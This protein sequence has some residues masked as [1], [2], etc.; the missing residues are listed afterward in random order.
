MKTEVYNEIMKVIH[1][2]T[3]S[4]VDPRRNCTTLL[5]ERFPDIP[6]YTL[7]SI[8]SLD[9]QRRMKRNHQRHARAAKDLYRRYNEI[10]QTTNKP[11]ALLQISDQIDLSPSLLARMI[12]DQHYERQAED[13][14]PAAT[15]SAITKLMKDT[16]LIKDSRL[17]YEIYLCILHDDQY[18]PITDTIKHSLGQEYELRL[19]RKIQELN[20]PF[21]DEELMRKH[22]YDKTP[23]VKLEVPIAVDGFIVNWIESKALFGDEEGHK[24]YMKE[25]Y[26]SYW[27]RF[28]P[29]LVIYWFG[30]LDYL[31]QF[32]DKKLIIR[33][34]FPSDITFMDP[35]SI[36]PTLIT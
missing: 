13:G 24:T 8:Y 11:G 36:K 30:Y 28:G 32:S 15:K 21:R 20:L 19:L 10:I 7:S 22:G 3:G 33:E 26:L 14:D 12:L 16:T 9:Y 35:K 5:Q 1:S 17:A 18:G 27:N 23:D 6:H 34:D 29:G 31:E 25:Q 2:Y 4:N